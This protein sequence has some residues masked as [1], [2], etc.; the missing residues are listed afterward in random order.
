M[1]EPVNGESHSFKAVCRRFESLKKQPAMAPLPGQ[2]Y[3]EAVDLTQLQSPSN[4]LSFSDTFRPSL[5]AGWDWQ[6]PFADCSFTLQEGLEIRAANGR[7]LWHL[8]LSA[9]RLL[10][11]AAG[12]FITQTVCRAVDPGLNHSQKPAIG[13][14]LVWQ[15]KCNFLRLV[16]GCRGQ[17]EITFEG[18]IDNE[19]VI[20]GRGLLPKPS[21]KTSPQVETL[22]SPPL[23]LR[24]TRQGNQIQAFCS[25]DNQQW[26]TVGQVVFPVSNPLKVGLHAVGWIDRLVYPGSHLEG[27]AIR[28]DS[29]EL[30]G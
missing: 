5:A 30:W 20:V 15:D 9:P 14:L 11:P 17:R 18:C 22:S 29:F 23:Y 13:G 2:W 26:F 19:N 3:L 6:D 7:D 16:W 4:T 21:L 1:Y 12:D 25:A 27:T 24:L 28:F 8:N 10:R